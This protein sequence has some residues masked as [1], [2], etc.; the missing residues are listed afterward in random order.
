MLRRKIQGVKKC[1]SKQNQKIYMDDI[2]RRRRQLIP[3]IEEFQLVAQHLLDV[4]NQESRSESHQ[5]EEDAWMFDDD[6]DD[7]Y[8]DGDGDAWME[9]EDEDDGFDVE[10]VDE[11][12]DEECDAMEPEMVVLY[13]PSTQGYSACVASGK[14][15]LM[16]LEIQ[17]RTG[18]ANDAL[19]QIR[20][21]ISYR[22]FLF[23]VEYREADNYKRKTR[24]SKAI[25]TVT[26]HIKKHVKAYSM[27]FRALGHLHAQ[28]SFQQLTK[29]DLK[30]NKDVV[31]ANRI[32]QSSDISSWIWRTGEV[33]EHEQQDI[34]LQEGK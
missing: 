10:L 34:F 3:Q 15:A 6:D 30:P 21:S 25:R 9:D 26:N 32:G 18:Q 11:T 14:T 12:D 22:D 5:D 24:S 28:G 7:D 31:E 13:L 16:D 29:S 19:S 33:S 1:R 2:T 17:I 8:D 20:A 27:A 4:N 23:K